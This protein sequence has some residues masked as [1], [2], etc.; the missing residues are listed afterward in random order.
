ME[1]PDRKVLAMRPNL[2]WGI[3]GVVLGLVAALTLP[4]IAQED[5]AEPATLDRTVSTTGVAI[6]RSAPDEALVTLGVR[7]DAASADEAM[8]ANADQM[9]SVIGALLDA[10][11]SEDQLA[12]A[13]L[14]LYPRW[15]TDG[16]EVIGFTAENQVTVTVHDL[17]RVGTIIDLAVDAGANLA[18]GITFR[19]SGENP[20]ADDALTE[21]VADARRKAELLA[22]AGGAQLGVVLTIA[23]LTSSISPPIIYEESAA[24]DGA[25]TQILPPTLESQ[26]SVSV[27]WALV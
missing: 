11:L 22:E 21:A 2:K 9:S 17:E 26:V 10:G 23:E 25:A 27:T 3:S 15:G 6:V 5:P 20:A 18:S 4:T 19:M 1:L 12:T 14:N 24:A 13:T 8:D 16:E 7:A